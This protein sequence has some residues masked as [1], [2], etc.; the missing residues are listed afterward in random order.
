MAGSLHGSART[1]PRVRVELQ[2]SRETTSILAL[3]CGLSR[4]T[5]A[6]W[7]SRTTTADAPM[8]P[9][10]PHG[11]VLTPQEEVMVVEFRR[12]TPAAARRGARR[13]S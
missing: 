10:A 12:R 1:T 13:P 11:T 6:R 2:A 8:G 5:M 9:S 4:T 7:R 3:R